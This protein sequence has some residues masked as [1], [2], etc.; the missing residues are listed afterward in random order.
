MAIYRQ[1][2]LIGESQTTLC[3][4][5]SQYFSSAESNRRSSSFTPFCLANDASSEVIGNPIETE[6][7]RCHFSAIPIWVRMGTAVTSTDGHISN[8]PP[9]GAQCSQCDQR[10][11]KTRS[12]DGGTAS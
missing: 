3:R 12:G 6:W 8:P 11:A 4:R 10:P 2:S 7:S 5:A 1:L 9:K